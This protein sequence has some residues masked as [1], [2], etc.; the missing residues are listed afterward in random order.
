MVGYIRRMLY[1]RRLWRDYGL[2]PH[3]SFVDV[4]STPAALLDF[5]LQADQAEAVIREQAMKTPPS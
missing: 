3:Q 5:F 4:R 2:R 1:Y